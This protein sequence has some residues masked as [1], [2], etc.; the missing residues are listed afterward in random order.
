MASMDVFN[1]SAF[2]MVSLT[3]AVDK[4]DY[5]PQLLGQLG[6]FEPMPVRTRTVFVDRRNGSLTLIPSS[7]TGAPPTELEGDDRDAVS[8]RTT[9]LAKSFTLYAEEVQGIRQFGSE[10]ELMQVQAEYMRR[11]ARIRDDMDLTHEYHRLGALQGKLLDADGTTVIYNYFTEFGIAE[12]SAIDFALTTDTTNVRGKCSQVIR[13]MQRAAKGAFTPA[14]SVHALVGDTFYDNLIDHPN[15][16]D[17]Y[18]NWAAASELRQ[19]LTFRSFPYGG[20][21][22]HNYQGTDDNSTVAIAA[23]EAKFFPVGARDVFKKAMAPAEF[24]PYVNTAGQDVYALNIPDR[25]R[26]AWTK[27]ELYSYP[28]YFCQRPSVLQKGIG[29]A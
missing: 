16:R 10:T 29:N 12:P 28:L 14:T 23:N 22:F 19:N 21:T 13:L 18:K 3:G 17:T 15:V 25:D 2:I 24:G 9:R 8:L 26:Q 5:K 11:M 1:S 6:I 4:I 27:G 20:I 7:P